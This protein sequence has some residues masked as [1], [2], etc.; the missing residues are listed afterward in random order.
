MK[1]LLRYLPVLC[2]YSLSSRNYWRM[3]WDVWSD[4]CC[5]LQWL[6]KKKRC[7]RFILVDGNSIGCC[8]EFRYFAWLYFRMQLV[9]R[10]SFCR[11]PFAF[12]SFVVV[13][14]TTGDEASH[15]NDWPTFGAPCCSWFVAAVFDSVALFAASACPEA[16]EFSHVSPLLVIEWCSSSI[17]RL[18]SSWDVLRKLPPSRI[19][20]I[21]VLNDPIFCNS[22]NCDW[23]L[24]SE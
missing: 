13:F 14:K 21:L 23:I 20:R 24:L 7:F 16:G 5:L 22:F 10:V 2:F 18:V 4:Y 9:F 12:R 1:K 8:Q 6:N 11:L 19:N 15:E 3:F 17:P